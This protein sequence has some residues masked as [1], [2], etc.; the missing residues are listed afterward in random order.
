LSVIVPTFRRFAPLLDTVQS[1]L[2]Q[3]DADFEI[4]VVDQNPSWPDALRDRKAH[5]ASDARVKWLVRDKPGVVASRHDA[6]DAAIGDIFVFIDDDVLIPDRFFLARHLANYEALPDLDVVVGREVYREQALPSVAPFPPPCTW[7]TTG[8]RVSGTPSSQA[9]SFDRMRPSRYAV[10]SFCTCNSS[11]RREA[12]FRVC[13][14]DEAFYGT[15][16]GDDYDFAIRLA[17]SG[18]RFVYDPHAWLIHLQAPTGGLRMS[19]PKN[20]L[21]EK[22]KIYSSILFL[23]KNEDSAWRW[24]LLWGVLRRSVLLKANL[25]RPW[26][27][28]PVWVGLWQAWREA[29]EAVRR[30]PISRF[31]PA[32]RSI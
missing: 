23:L 7:F 12:F 17:R 10:V 29:R 22:E 6:V 31:R 16:Y 26:R 30:G 21:T 8:E 3:Q 4:V 28:P 24:Y 2:V 11:V 27:Q 19:D 14:F 13:G 20:R 5:V 18:G 25:E 1:L 9:M 32:S 15:A